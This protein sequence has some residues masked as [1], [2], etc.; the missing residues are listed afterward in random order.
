MEWFIIVLLLVVVALAAGYYRG[1]G[2]GQPEASRR[3][4]AER[5]GGWT[6]GLRAWLRASLAICTWS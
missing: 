2:S 3:G 1:Q 6:G 4:A 5:P